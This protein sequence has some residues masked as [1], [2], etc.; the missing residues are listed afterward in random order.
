MT[1]A[2]ERNSYVKTHLT[3]IT[4]AFYML[5][6]TAYYADSTLAFQLTDSASQYRPR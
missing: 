3:Y 1:G 5:G 6:G 4:R 2:P